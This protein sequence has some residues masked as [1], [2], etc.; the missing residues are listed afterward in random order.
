[1]NPETRDKPN[2]TV[3]CPFCLKLNRINLSRAKDRPKCGEC[4]KPILLDRPVKVGD[5]DLERVVANS[6]APVLVD[7]YADW[8]GPCKIMAPLL[9]QVAQ[10]RIGEVLVTKLDTDRSPAMARRFN[11]RGIPTLILFRDGIE[12]ARE[13]GAVPR[14][15]L[16]AMLQQAGS[17]R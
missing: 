9:D 11:I 14:A 2:A 6:D 13:V 1:M 8:C 10:E 5:Q 12:V 7:F 4:G 3:P 15:R 16:E 17:A